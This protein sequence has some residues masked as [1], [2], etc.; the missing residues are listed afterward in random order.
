[1]ANKQQ[2]GRKPSRNQIRYGRLA[3]GWDWRTTPEF[4]KQAEKAR[5]AMGITRTEFIEQALLH[6]AVAANTAWSGQVATSAK[7]DDSKK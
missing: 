3:R 6:Y 2:G 7:K 5:K 1:M 4:L